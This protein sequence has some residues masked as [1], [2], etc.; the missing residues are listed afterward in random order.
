MMEKPRFEFLARISIDPE[1]PDGYMQQYI[2]LPSEVAAWCRAER[3][4]RT[5]GSL[6]GE[7]LDALPVPFRRAL[8]GGPE[9][10]LRLR[11]GRDW[12][13]DAGLAEGMEVAVS[14][15]QDPN[16]DHVDMPIELETA[17]AS[18]PE[19]ERV[20]E[21]LTAGRRRSLAYALERV[22][23]PETRARKALE[24][25]AQLRKDHLEP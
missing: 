20:W 15:M 4:T 13:R 1:V 12:L 21:G 22:K 2:E 9:G 23:R 17:L 11:F 3:V 6:V 10:T 25:V 14:F 5:A 18:D 19:V 7:A 24:L 8:H 16:P